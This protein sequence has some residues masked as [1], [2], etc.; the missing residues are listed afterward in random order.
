[1]SY[2]IALTPTSAL[3]QAI[4][5]EIS[6]LQDINLAPELYNVCVS[7]GAGTGECSDLAQV[8]IS[9]YGDGSLTLAKVYSSTKTFTIREVS[10]GC[11]NQ[12]QSMVCF[13][14]VSPEKQVTSGSLISVSAQV[15]SNLFDK[16]F[17]GF[18]L[19]HIDYTPINKLL[20][21]ILGKQR[22]GIKLRASLFTLY[23]RY[24]SEIARGNT[25]N[26]PSGYAVSIVYSPDA[27]VTFRSA[28][29]YS[30]SNHL[31]LD[32]TY[33]RDITLYPVQTFRH[34]I[35]LL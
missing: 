9:V 35:R 2:S 16:E 5:S 11:V 18:V 17:S 15:R 7:D 24:G 29:I 13:T 25:T 26:D 28:K 12:Y 31:L 23:D 8:D 4:A 32:I 33:E 14:G 34:D 3:K 1:M 21:Y 19:A 10:L 22:G 6:A 20:A 27:V 30:S